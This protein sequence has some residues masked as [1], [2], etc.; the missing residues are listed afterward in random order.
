MVQG[1]PD[2]W[3][4]PG[5]LYH[6]IGNTIIALI[7]QTVAAQAFCR[8]TDVLVELRAQKRVVGFPKVQFVVCRMV[9][10][11]FFIPPS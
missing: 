10:C 6:T 2:R 11:H 3:E 1:A 8:L 9:G 4:D 7:A 5:S